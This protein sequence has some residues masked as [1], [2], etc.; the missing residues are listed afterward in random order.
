VHVHFILSKESAMTKTV[1]LLTLVVAALAGMPAHAQPLR[2][3]VS[4]LGLDTNPCTT[5]QPCRTFQQAYNTAAVNGEIDVLDP[6]GYGPLTI[7]HGI[8][9]QAH[10]FG[11]I[12]ATCN[13][14]AAI[15]ISVTTGDPVTLNGLLIDGGGT[16][17]YGILITSGS[18]VQVLGSVIRHFAS[19]G[20]LN[21]TSTNGA[22]LL[23]EDTIT[24]DNQDIGIFVNPIA[25]ISSATLSRVTANNNSVGV[26]TAANNTTI[27]NSVMSNNSSSGL[28]SEGGIVWVAKNV[29]SGNMTGVVLS[30]GTVNSYGDNYIRDNG[31]PVSGGSLMPASTQ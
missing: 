15:K 27:A 28:Q 24:S 4:G 13:S 12:T 23:I 10:G 3:F 8:S 18:S 21:L 30:G 31:T 17:R 19:I 14:C 2:V 26:N 6:A 11:G 9:I 5:T 1:F 16:G 29:I 20:I 7:T 25:M 22:N